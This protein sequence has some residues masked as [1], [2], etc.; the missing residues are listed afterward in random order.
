MNCPLLSQQDVKLCSHC[1]QKWLKSDF[2]GGS[3]DQVRLFSNFSPDLFFKIRVRPLPYVVRIKTWFF[4]LRPQCE[5]AM[6]LLYAGWSP[7]HF[8]VFA[9][10]KSWN[11]TLNARVL[12]VYFGLS[13]NAIVIV[14]MCMPVSLVQRTVNTGITYR[15][16]FKWKRDQPNKKS[17][18]SKEKTPNQADLQCECSSR[19][20]DRCFFLSAYKAFSNICTAAYSHWFTNTLPTEAHKY[21]PN[22]KQAQRSP[23]RDVCSQVVCVIVVCVPVFTCMCLLARALLAVHTNLICPLS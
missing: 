21:R 20:I 1:R 8:S 18:H 13:P 11:E 6:P 22:T 15:V 10:L 2:C 4:K 9:V 5:P 16:S 17:D 19:I 12:H 23:K 14:L 7:V 3:N